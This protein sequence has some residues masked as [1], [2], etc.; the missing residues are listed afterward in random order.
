MR[1]P[2]VLLAIAAAPLLAAGAAN[3]Q[4]TSGTSVGG[5]TAD[6][7]VTVE[8]PERMVWYLV[9]RT[10]TRMRSNRVC[11][12]VSQW[13]EA[14]QGRSQDEE[15]ADAADT[16]DT[17]GADDISTNDQVDPLGVNEQGILNARAHDTPLGPR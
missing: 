9:R 16:L 6:P 15:L 5:A 17:F 11:R 14:R 8:G 1:K 12:T 3:A 7:G 10:G 2:I 4:S 13:H